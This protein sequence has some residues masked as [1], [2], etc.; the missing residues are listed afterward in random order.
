MKN[1]WRS[2]FLALWNICILSLQTWEK[3]CRRNLLFLAGLNQIFPKLPTP[4][5]ILLEFHSCL[6]RN[7]KWNVALGCFKNI[8]HLE[9]TRSHRKALPLK[10][11]FSS[12]FQK[13]FLIPLAKLC[14]YED[15]NLL[16][17]HIQAQH[18]HGTILN[19]CSVFACGVTEDQWQYIK[20]NHVVA[21]L[22]YNCKV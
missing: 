17:A 8:S 2:L 13:H 6:P 18:E 1:R 10:R 3:A 16:V 15:L 9:T 12:F 21:L 20:V 14:I 5:F 7:E 19:S 4:C 22:N 11:T